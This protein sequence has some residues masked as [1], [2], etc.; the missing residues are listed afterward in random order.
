MKI[1]L[2]SIL[3]SISIFVENTNA[4]ADQSF[5]RNYGQWSKLGQSSKLAY[6]AGAFD[7]LF[8]SMF[9]DSG[10]DAATSADNDG[11]KTCVSETG[12][13]EQIMSQMIDARYLKHS[14]EWTFG[15]ASVLISSLL[16]TCDPQIRLARVKLGLPA[17]R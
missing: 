14:E 9:A 4:D 11:I 6:V 13:N 12:M 17:I 7:E 1:V 8:N 15:P 3:F 2:I 5:I 10:G 16:E